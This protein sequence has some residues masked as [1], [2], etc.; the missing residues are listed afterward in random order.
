MAEKSDTEYAHWEKHEELQEARRNQLRSAIQSD[1]TLGKFTALLYGLSYDE[2]N[3][4]TQA[5]LDVPEEILRFLNAVLMIF[6]KK[7]EHERIYG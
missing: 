3:W 5:G 2:L 6:E 7:V 4:I 1:M